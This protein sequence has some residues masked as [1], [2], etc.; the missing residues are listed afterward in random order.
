VLC[1][2]PGIDP[3]GILFHL[4]YLSKHSGGS[5]YSLTRMTLQ[6]RM[7][8]QGFGQSDVL[9]N[10]ISPPQPQLTMERLVH[11]HLERAC[12]GVFQKLNGE[13]PFLFHSCPQKT[14]PK[15]KKKGKWT[16]QKVFI[17]RLPWMAPLSAFSF[18]A[19]DSLVHLAGGRKELEPGR[20]ALY[21]FRRPIIPRLVP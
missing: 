19:R 21:S 7:E 20:P 2:A 4:K 11:S 16:K 9:G 5:N 13:M 6:K 15:K 3:G 17:P 10:E 12:K 8:Q 1:S 14:K 18:F